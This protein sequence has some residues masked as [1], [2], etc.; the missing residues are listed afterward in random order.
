VAADT[1]RRAFL[2]GWLAVTLVPVVALALLAPADGTAPGAPFAAVLFVASSVH[3]AATGWFYTVPE[4][5]P[6]LL[7]RPA[8][9]VYAPAALVVGGAAVAELLSGRTLAWV[10]LAF[11]GWQFFHF[12]KQNLGLAAL[13]ARASGAPALTGAERRALLLTG[14]GGLLGICGQ[15][16]LIQLA[17]APHL[18]PVHW[19]GAGLF[20]LGVAAGA[21]ALT[22]RAAQPTLL[23]A[24]A[25]GLL[26]FLP[27][28]LVDSPY[29]AVAGLTIAHG[30]QYLLLLALVAGA[31]ATDRPLALLVLVNVALLLGLA[32]SRM[33]HLHG[34]GTVARALFGVY[35]GLSC[36][37]FVVDAGVWRLRD[38]FPRTFLTRRLPY[39]LAPERVSG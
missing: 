9:Y 3:V 38:E 34:G 2:A 24:L 18:A 22:R 16:H 20:G 39:L 36:A 5:R 33:A 15:P 29:A 13:T 4:L 37:H 35:L 7:A 25:T 6:H 28:W 1:A 10:L 21:W 30:L 8:R 26:F 17:G 12:Q 11:F 32:L 27:V 19:A 23:L 31:P 14:T